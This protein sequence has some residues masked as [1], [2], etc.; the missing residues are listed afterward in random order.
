MDTGPAF[1]VGQA[2]AVRF[3]T[4]AET[5]R[6][7][8]GRDGLPRWTRPKWWSRQTLMLP[9]AAEVWIFGGSIAALGWPR[10]MHPCDL[11]AVSVFLTEGRNRAAEGGA[12]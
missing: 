12:S 5:R 6:I 9:T 7:G 11:G 10:G 1:E 3:G 8:P 4:T 2:A